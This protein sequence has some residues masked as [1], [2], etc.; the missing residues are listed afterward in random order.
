MQNLL[1][2]CNKIRWNIA[3]LVNIKGHFKAV[4]AHVPLNIYR[5]DKNV[6]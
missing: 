6:G 5:G 4:S 2:W 3:V 1:P